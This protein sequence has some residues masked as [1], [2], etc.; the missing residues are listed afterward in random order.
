MS[1][2]RSIEE[3]KMSATVSRYCCETNLFRYL[4]IVMNMLYMF[5]YVDMLSQIILQDFESIGLHKRTLVEMSFVE[6][7][8]TL[9]E[10]Y[11]APTWLKVRLPKRVELN[12]QLSIVDL[13]VPSSENMFHQALIS[14]LSKHFVSNVS[15]L[16][17]WQSMKDT[18][19]RR[20]DIM[21]LGS[22]GK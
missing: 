5:L 10:G 21:L 6:G 13:S 14:H 22:S 12:K 17:Y 2:P 1:S 15:Q 8:M 20:R 18:I 16:S 7:G 11:A 9:E 4:I 3:A 19:E